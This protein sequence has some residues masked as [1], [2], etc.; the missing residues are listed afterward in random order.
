[1][2]PDG[3]LIFVAR[4]DDQVKIHDQ[5]IELGEINNI[6]LQDEAVRDCT[7]II[8]DLENKSHQ[9]LI[10]FWTPA[11][12]AYVPGDIEAYRAVIK[13]LYNRLCLVLPHYMIPSLLIP[14]DS[15]PMTVV[16][17]LDHRRLKE[18]ISQLTCDD[19]SVFSAYYRPSSESKELSEAEASLA[20]II[21]D[22]LGVAQQKIHRYTSFYNIGLDSISAIY[23]SRRLRNAGF[24]QLDVSS[25][26]R[27]SSIA[28]LLKFIENRA[29][30]EKKIIES[31]DSIEV[32]RKV[33]LEQAEST[34][35]PLGM[36]VQSVIPCTP[37]QEI[38][39]SRASSNWDAYYNHFLLKIEGDIE[40][41]RKAW[42]YMVLRHEILRTCFIASDNATFAHAQ[43]IFKEVDLPWVHI[44][45][46]S[47][48]IPLI[49]EEQ[50]SHL[51]YQY[52][53][54]HTL[55]YSF[56]VFED[57]RNNEVVLLLS[58]HHALHDGEAMSQLFQEVELL[59]AGEQ[60]PQTS[61]FRSFI[62]YMLQTET[63]ESE[64]FWRQYLSGFS[65]PR[66]CLS[67]KFD[68]GLKSSHRRQ[69]SVDLDMSLETF[70]EQCRKLSVSILNVFHAAWARLL[71][72]Y[73]NSSDVC[74]GNVYSCR[75]IPL[76]DMDKVVGPCFNTLPVRI[77]LHPTGTNIDVMKAAQE[78]NVDILPHQLYSLRK[79]IKA[80][81]TLAGMHLF[82]TL[83]LL[84]SRQP[85]LDCRLWRLVKEEGEMDFPVICEITPSQEQSHFNITLHLDISS[86]SLSDVE[87]LA[88]N[89]ALIVS[90]TIRYPYAQAADQSILT[91]TLPSPK[92]ATA[93]CE[94]D[95]G[96]THTIS[97]S[98]FLNRK[99]G[100]WSEDENRVR[101]ILSTLS[102][103][104]CEY[105]KKDTTIFQ[106]GLDSINVVQI[107]NALNKLGYDVLVRD[108]L[109]VRR[110]L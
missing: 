24:G 100:A 9:Q 38:M 68:D 62:E 36:V 34:F 25:I 110:Q 29:P 107:S 41:L 33:F 64:S 88:H 27:N 22:T 66:H 95:S 70:E 71:A 26:L 97:V 48:K 47:D 6:L 94:D 16:K 82:D 5:R 20:S 23:L 99:Q 77:R 31:Q 14:I 83:I 28:R 91:G 19:L 21:V 2:L 32:C 46:S 63:N 80:N 58:I 42:K 90:D 35:R 60:L 104:R 54:K 93:S 51:V 98:D 13:D 37:L 79:I 18:I 50:K 101:D 10:S 92:V 7:T 17:K 75:T 44:D 109:E 73:T 4:Q 87:T 1:M 11:C 56:C 3:S 102:G 30:E 85:S 39:L 105:I 53:Y 12:G 78:S 55:P 57:K 81:S 59:Y 65:P 103:T 49:M 72:F 8:V 76:D 89:F 108:I 69:I 106:L 45:A 74:F 84:Q 86:R 43:V 96:I 67:Q 52:R 40:R 61:Q 15:I